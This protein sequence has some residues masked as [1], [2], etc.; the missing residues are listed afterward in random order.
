MHIFPQMLARMNIKHFLKKAPKFQINEILLYDSMHN[1]TVPALKNTRHV[2]VST[3]YLWSEVTM[4][5]LLTP[6][7]SNDME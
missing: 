1:Y 2:K 3:Q 5:V 6:E 7:E 4:E